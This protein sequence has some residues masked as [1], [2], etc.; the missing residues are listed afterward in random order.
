MLRSHAVEEPQPSSVQT[1]ADP[2]SPRWWVLR[3]KA[4]QEKAVAKYLDAAG[5]E[6]FLPTQVRKQ[7][8]LKG[9]RSFAHP[10]F[11]G[12]VFAKAAGVL[13]EREMGVGRVVQLVRVTDQA[14]LEHELAQIRAAMLAG[15][16]LLP[17]KFLERGTPVVV[18]HGPLK[19]VEGVVERLENPESM[20]LQVQTLGRALTVEIS[21][22]IIALRH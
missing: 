5:V 17:A 15:A 14:R 18:T 11:P 8:W 19:G 9:G 10:L 22:T 2:A 4:R 21:P 3:T 16:V 7:P 6:H 13:T 1:L 20:W 12:Y